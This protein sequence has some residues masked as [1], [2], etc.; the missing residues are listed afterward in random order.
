MIRNNGEV[1]SV[2]KLNMAHEKSVDSM[3]MKNMG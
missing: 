1:I 2:S 3:I